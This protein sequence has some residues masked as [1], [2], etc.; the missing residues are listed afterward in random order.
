MFLSWS[1]SLFNSSSLAN[2]GFFLFNSE[3][4]ASNNWRCLS[5]FFA[6]DS[7]RKIY[8]N[9]HAIMNGDKDVQAPGMK[10]SLLLPSNS[11]L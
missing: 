6:S 11:F 7:Y 3:I 2:H 10:L 4:F 5:T 1:I 8:Y 9:A